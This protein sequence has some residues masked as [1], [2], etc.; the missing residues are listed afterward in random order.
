MF[1]SDVGFRNIAFLTLVFGALGDWGST[2]LGLALGLVEGNNLAALLMSKGIWMRSDLMF[3]SL[4]FTIPVLV[5]RLIK[6]ELPNKLFWFP[7]L[8]GT[9]KIGVSLW[10]ITQI[11]I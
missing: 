5:N 4:C 9:M 6:N 1:R 11:I 3:L 8:A 10:N 7:L 2:K